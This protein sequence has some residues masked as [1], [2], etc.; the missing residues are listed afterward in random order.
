MNF[1]EI[2]AADARLAI[3]QALVREASRSHNEQLLQAALDAVGIVR[4]RD[5][6]R[7]QMRALE[8]TGAVTLRE[9]GDLLIATLTRTG[10]DHLSG[11]AIIDR[12]AQPEP[13]A[14]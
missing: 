8:S 14:L 13:G 1:H 4:A 10:L 3:L 11:R 6:T 7:T 12:V 5:Y 2:V 9:A